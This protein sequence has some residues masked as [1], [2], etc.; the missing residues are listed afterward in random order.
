MSQQE[1]KATV[2]S[3]VEVEKESL[4]GTDEPSGSNEPCD[5]GI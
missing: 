5:I 4:G 2:Q 1:L 3:P